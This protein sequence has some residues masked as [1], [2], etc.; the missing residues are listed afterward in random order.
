MSS[1]QTTEVLE[2]PADVR[3]EIGKELMDVL[4]GFAKGSD[5]EV[6]KLFQQELRYGYVVKIDRDRDQP[7]KYVIVVS[8]V[9]G[10]CQILHRAT[11]SCTLSLLEKTSIARA[12]CLEGCKS[13][14]R[15]AMSD[16]LASQRLAE[17]FLAARRQTWN[18]L[19]IGCQIH[20]STSA[21]EYGLKLC[22]PD[23]KGLIHFALSLASGG[24]LRLWRRAIFNE[25]FETLV[26]LDGSCSQD[27][28]EYRLMAIRVFAGAGASKREVQL[29]M[30]VLPNG[31]WRNHSVVEVYIPHAVVVNKRVVAAVVASGLCR[32]F[33]RARFRT[34]QRKRWTL[35]D[36]AV[37][38]PGLMAACHCLLLRTYFRFL[39]L[40]GH[41]LSDRA[42]K[43]AF[44]LTRIGQEAPLV[45]ADL[46]SVHEVAPDP[47]EGEPDVEDRDPNAP[48]E[49]IDGAASAEAGQQQ[50]GDGQATDYV[51]QN[52]ASRNHAM[53]WLAGGHFAGLVMLRLQMEA[54]MAYLKSQLHISSAAWETGQRAKGLSVDGGP[55]QRDFRLLV[56]ARG[57]L[58]EQ[59]VRRQFV[60]GTEARLWSLLPDDAVTEDMCCKAFRVMNRMG[61][62]NRRMLGK[63]NSLPPFLLFLT[64]QQQQ[65]AWKRLS[66]LPECLL[67]PFSVAYLQEW[68]PRTVE[69]RMVL[70]LIMLLACTDTAP[71]EC[72][73]AWARRLLIRLSVQTHR[74]SILDL[75]A[76]I[77]AHRFSSYAEAQCYW[78]PA[79]DS[80]AQE[81][82]P[83]DHEEE[84]QCGAKR[85][86]T[87]TAW[88]AHNSRQRAA[89]VPVEKLSESYK[90][91]TAEQVA[92]DERSASD[93]NERKESGAQNPFGMNKRLL[94]SKGLIENA[95][96]FLVRNA[97]CGG[98]IVERCELAHANNSEL[99]F[100]DS[101]S[102][103]AYLLKV[104]RRVERLEGQASSNANE[105]LELAI[106]KYADDDGK[107]IVED[108]L[109][110]LPSL[111]PFAGS[112]FSMPMQTQEGNVALVGCCTRSTSVAADC[113]SKLVGSYSVAQ[114]R[115]GTALD[116]FW[117]ASH[118]PVCGDDGEG[119]P[120][121]DISRFNPTPCFIAGHCLCSYEG[122]KLHRF[123][124]SIF[125][126]LKF[127]YPQSSYDEFKPLA[128]GFVVLVLK[129]VPRESMFA[130]LV[131]LESDSSDVCEDEYRFLSV[132]SLLQNPYVPTYLPLQCLD[133]EFRSSLPEDIELTVK[134]FAVVV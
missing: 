66:S 52:S 100:S 33:A 120:T 51:K 87:L 12:V 124:N 125:K 109:A 18:L 13:R 85:R 6:V 61:G 81:P 89:G 29:L 86:A 116:K 7:P 82:G 39:K 131:G 133:L 5:T 30:Q 28:L 45:A 14:I 65:Q 96:R 8:D 123:R 94:E 92:E 42:L 35:N 63:P 106:R 117:V 34:F 64:V 114:S 126:N 57:D 40:V 127:C 121:E 103:F 113:V 134:A 97:L 3:E 20:M 54:G 2:L 111:Q 26:I 55:C 46:A 37:S 115:L 68:D 80:A 69:G 90:N 73:H 11:T 107:R 21:T 10:T 70:I 105:E 119:M 62:N 24:W 93:A 72:W 44:N 36:E 49:P 25:V 122:K 19:Q 59:F 41:K 4:V 32:V 38:K 71:I 104:V 91:R 98:S 50:N 129:G 132:A 23:I 31:E 118:L 22:D 17:K 48:E 78:F 27:A 67:D 128:D 108:T 9:V 77:V 102:S 43:A 16:R 112:L 58:D 130:D 47:H 95:Q 110:L 79:A 83:E 75:G 101:V 56:A 74:M 76:R 1:P 99:D 53:E 15:I 84:V 88:H 60:L